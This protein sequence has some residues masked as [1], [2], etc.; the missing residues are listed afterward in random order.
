MCLH[1]YDIHIWFSYSTLSSSQ[2]CLRHAVGAA[3]LANAAETMRRKQWGPVLGNVFSV[4]ECNQG[5][6][7]DLNLE[8][9]TKALAAPHPPNQWHNQSA[10]IQLDSY[11]KITTGSHDYSGPNDLVYLKLIM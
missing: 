5:T 1:Q 4:P 8:Q 3:A 9:Y 6:E 7:K 10:Q 11:V 2:T